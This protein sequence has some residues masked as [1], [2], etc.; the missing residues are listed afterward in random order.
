MRRGSNCTISV[1]ASDIDEDD[2]QSVYIIIKQRGL[3]ITQEATLSDS[4]AST[5]LDLETTRLLKPG[6][7]WLQVSAILTDD[8]VVQSDIIRY[9]IDDTLMDRGGLIGGISSNG[10]YIEYFN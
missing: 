3:T 4:I 9:T 8:S 5:E 6:R 7:I 10:F 1:T 2:V